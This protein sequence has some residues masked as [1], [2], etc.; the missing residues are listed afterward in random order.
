M[1]LSGFLSHGGYPF[2]KGENFGALDKNLTICRE[3]RF[4]ER[5][6]DLEVGLVVVPWSLNP[7]VL[8]SFLSRLHGGGEGMIA[9]NGKRKENVPGSEMLLQLLSQTTLSTTA[10][11]PS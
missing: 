8:Q 7:F 2:L 3:P 4:A 6:S 11:K 9:K 10:I 1:R 5:C